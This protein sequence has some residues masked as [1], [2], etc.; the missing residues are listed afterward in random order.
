MSRRRN[1]RTASLP[2]L[3]HIR[4]TE[5]QITTDTGS[6]SSSS[7]NA[8]LIEETYPLPY[9][10][11]RVRSEGLPTPIQSINDLNFEPARGIDRRPVGDMQ[12]TDGALEPRRE[13]KSAPTHSFGGWTFPRGAGWSPE[14]NAPGYGRGVLRQ[15]E[16][17]SE[18]RQRLAN[19][20]TESTLIAEQI[21]QEALHRLKSVDEE[22]QIGF[23]PTE[24]E[25]FHELGEHWP[26]MGIL[27]SE[28]YLDRYRP[29]RGFHALMRYYY[30]F[31]M[32]VMRRIPSRMAPQRLIHWV[33][34]DTNNFLDLITLF[35]TAFVMIG[36]L[37]L[38][39][40]GYVY[41]HY[42]IIAEGPPGHKKIVF[43]HKAL[44]PNAREEILSKPKLFLGY[45]GA[46]AISS[47]GMCMHFIQFMVYMNGR[48]SA[49]TPTKGPP[50]G[51]DSLSCLIFSF[52]YVGVFVSTVV[53][54][55]RFMSETAR[56]GVVMGYAGEYI[57]G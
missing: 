12:M 51:C 41:G 44:S 29:I 3:S 17:L 14:G 25:N 5:H 30:G 52:M 34:Y 31:F 21:L 28:W 24:H 40:V 39:E 16:R 43:Q 38:V 19:K 7:T 48:S 20:P 27:N 26:F 56:K 2:S 54:M 49:A 37:A 18:L 42:T 57:G 15:M 32:M 23:D 11:R 47:V 46:L 6:S 55:E 4:G 8:G 10:G 22:R 33:Y 1:W 53:L 50:V 36:V 13:L 45:Y 9:R 35:S